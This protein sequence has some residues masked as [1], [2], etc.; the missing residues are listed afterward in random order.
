MTH[1]R[2]QG[3]GDDGRHRVDAR[4]CR[5]W[6]ARSDRATRAAQCIATEIT[7]ETPGSCMV[8]P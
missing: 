7:F 1:S 3:R 5:R 6:R 2:G 4:Q 8:T